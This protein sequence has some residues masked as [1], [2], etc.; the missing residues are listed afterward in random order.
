M[1]FQNN[2]L[3]Q[4][5]VVTA[6]NLWHVRATN[7]HMAHGAW[8]QLHPNG[9]LLYNCG[10][11]N[12]GGDYGVDWVDQA[13]YVWLTGHLPAGFVFTAGPNQR[14]GGLEF[15]NIT[16]A[17]GPVPKPKDEARQVDHRPATVGGHPPSRGLSPLRTPEPALVA[18]RM[19]EA[20]TRRAP[21]GSRHGVG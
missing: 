7:Q 5:R 13:L 20:V 11:V 21:V 8:Y 19:A 15:Y 2:P 6:L 3:H 12:N 16:R 1:Q 18:R 14:W 9:S 10:G 4:G 17:S